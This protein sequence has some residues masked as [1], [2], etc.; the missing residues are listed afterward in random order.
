M[1]IE[2]NKVVDVA[3][4]LYVDGDN[5]ELELMEKATAEKP[6]HFIYGI[7]M[8]LPAFEKEMF[9]LSKGDTFDFT[10]SKEDAYGEYEDEAVVDL[11]RAVFEV[12]GKIDTDLIKE[13][14]IVPLMDN[15]GNR[16]QGLVAKVT[17]THV[18]VDLNHPLAGETLHF[19]GNVLEVK[20]ATEEELNTLLGGGCGCGN[21]GCG[22]GEDGQEDCGC[23]DGHHHQHNGN[24]G[25][26]CDCGC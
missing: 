17:D 21:G 9:G 5:G 6:L 2:Q 16:L 3:Y 18:T 10:L 14:N 7:G 23:D 19:K 24:S 20:E 22:C 4:E 15:Q 25:C 12:D 1:K 13:G 26:G 11:E 8:M